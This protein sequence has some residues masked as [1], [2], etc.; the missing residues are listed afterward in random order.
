MELG[1]Y[2]ESYEFFCDQITKDEPKV[3]DI[4]C[5]PGNISRFIKRQI[6]KSIVTGIDTAENM[7]AIAQQNVSTAH[8]KLLDG[9]KV[10]QLNQTFDAIS[11]GFCIPFF[12]SSELVHF[13]GSLAKITTENAVV[14]LSFVDGDNKDSEYKNGSGGNRLF[15]NYHR[16]EDLIAIFQK[17]GFRNEN[18]FKIPYKNG[19]EIIDI[20]TVLLFRKRK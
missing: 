13:I 9:R 20:H 1:I 17:Q 14:Y 8:F 10:E 2:N 11:C 19:E 7:I 4:G 16:S 18:K 12:T 3:L 15:F 6:P 5:G